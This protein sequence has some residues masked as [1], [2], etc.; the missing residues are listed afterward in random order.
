[1]ASIG[2]P[3]AQLMAAQHNTNP[4]QVMLTAVILESVMVAIVLLMDGITLL[5]P[6]MRLA[7]CHQHLYQ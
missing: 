1:M 6:Q 3:L 5:I 7:L 2:S 4:A